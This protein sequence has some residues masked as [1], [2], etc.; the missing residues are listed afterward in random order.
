[1]S[2]DPATTERGRPLW[3]AVALGLALLLAGAAMWLDQRP[4]PVADDAGPVDPP[5][6]ETPQAPPESAA[7]ISRRPEAKPAPPRPGAPERL[8]IPSLDVDSPVVPIRAPGGVLTP[9]ADPQTLGWWADGARPGD[10]RGSA[11]VTGHTV[12]TGGGA[13]DNLEQVTTGAMVNVRSAATTTSYDV[14]SVRIYGKGELAA[15]A[16][17]LFDQTVRGRLVVITCEDWNGVE[18]LSNVVV[19]A[20][21]A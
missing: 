11:L 17:E 10:A 6:S 20:T 14:R 3:W 4:T 18:Y 16:E 1:M 21:P 12:S 15:R 13:L 7:P 8:L 19:T 5:S 9:P 2:R